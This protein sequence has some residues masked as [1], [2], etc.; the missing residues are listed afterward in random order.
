M[1]PA[2]APNNKNILELS[3]IIKQFKVRTT[4]F[5][6][7]KIV[8][9]LDGINFGMEQGDILSLVGESGCGKTTVGKIV[10]GLL[11]P[12]TGEVRYHQNNIWSKD[13]KAFKD[14]RRKVQMIHQDPY[15]SLNPSQRVFDIL[16]APLYR[17]K[18]VKGRADA[19]QKVADLMKLVDL[20]PV[21][22]F[23][24]KYP[25]QLSGGQRQ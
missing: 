1:P 24:Y 20:S 3:Q 14:F 23:I 13:K 18:L 16:S 2:S 7:A 6:R 5:G 21:D 17:Y 4:A 10:T 15:T 8:T 19:E 12:T 9:V 11:K 25:H 22:D